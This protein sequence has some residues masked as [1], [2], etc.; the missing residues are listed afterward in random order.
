MTC[1]EPKFRQRVS[2]YTE[3]NRNGANLGSIEFRSAPKQF[4]NEPKIELYLRLRR[5]LGDGDVIVREFRDIGKFRQQPVRLCEEVRV[6]PV[7]DQ[8]LVPASVGQEVVRRR[9]DQPASVRHQRVVRDDGHVPENH[10][11]Q[12]ARW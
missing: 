6:R 3:K 4:R 1:F 11:G 9:E 10:F 8:Q 5:P 2:N 7:A 12:P